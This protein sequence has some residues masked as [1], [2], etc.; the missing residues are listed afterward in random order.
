MTETAH[1][2]RAPRERTIIPCGRCKTNGQVLVRGRLLPCP[3]CLGS[4]YWIVSPKCDRVVYP[5]P[6]P[7]AERLR[8]GRRTS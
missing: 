4:G 2:L 1:T 5:L 7:L 6:T 3:E 8:E